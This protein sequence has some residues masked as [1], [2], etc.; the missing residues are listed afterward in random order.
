MQQKNG[1][2]SSWAVPSQ[3]GSPPAAMTAMLPTA[4]TDASVK[5][6]ISTCTMAKTADPCDGARNHGP[7]SPKKGWR[8][9]PGLTAGIF[10]LHLTPKQDQTREKDAREV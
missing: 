7:T 2:F 4:F 3:G 8:D 1:L 6:Q 9:R 5:D 10:K